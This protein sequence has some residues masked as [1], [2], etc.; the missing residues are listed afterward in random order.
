MSRNRLIQF[1]ALL[2]LV[3]FFLPYIVKLQQTDLIIVLLAGI[4]MP[5]Y[6]FFRHKDN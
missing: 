3:L 5:V 2:L 6:D 4:A 1:I